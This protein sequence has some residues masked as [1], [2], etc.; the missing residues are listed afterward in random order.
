MNLVAVAAILIWRRKTNLSYRWFFL[1]FAIFP[2]LDGIATAASVHGKLN[3]SFIGWV[4]L[5]YLSLA[6][7]S[8]P[9]LRWCW[10]RFGRQGTAQLLEPEMAVAN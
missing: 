1:G 4:E 2:L 10:V 5:A 9:N 3:I 8:I 7:V 6:L